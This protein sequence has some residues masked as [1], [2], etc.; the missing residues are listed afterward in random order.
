MGRYSNH[1]NV[2]T[3]QDILAGQERDRPPA[4]TTRSLRKK[5]VQHRLEPEEVD[6]LVERYRTGTKI[7]DLAAEFAISRTAVMNH[8]ERAGSPRRRNVLTDRLDQARQLYDEGWSLAKIAQH[9]GVNAST[10]WHALRKAGVPMRETHG[11]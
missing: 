1:D 5:Q 8:V 10:V 9:F 2:T 3:L 6:R 7:N 4:R 11:R